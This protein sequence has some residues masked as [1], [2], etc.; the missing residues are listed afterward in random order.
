MAC[1]KEL[2]LPKKWSKYHHDSVNEAI[3]PELFDEEE[4]FK[5]IVALGL[6]DRHIAK[7]YVAS[8]GPYLL[9][10]C[11][12]AVIPNNS[13]CR[14]VFKLF[15]NLSTSIFI[16]D[17]KKETFS[18]IEMRQLCDAFQMLDRQLCEQFPRLPTLA[19]M[20]Q[21]LRKK[22]TDEKLIPQVLELMDFTNSVVKSL[23]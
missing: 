7:K 9:M 13:L 2:Q 16:S 5:W 22:G 6:C 19:E 23:L 3:D 10:R 4:C 11:T 17:D 8:A 12:V 1:S 15:V 14:E 20:K 18:Q 21:S